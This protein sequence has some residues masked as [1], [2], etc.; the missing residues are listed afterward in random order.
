MEPRAAFTMEMV[1]TRAMVSSQTF[2]DTERVATVL[3]ELQN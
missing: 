2:L 3:G 1:R